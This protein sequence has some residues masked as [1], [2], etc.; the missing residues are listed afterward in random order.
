MVHVD[1]THSGLTPGQRTTW[2]ARLAAPV[3]AVLLVCVWVAG[4]GKVGKPKTKKGEVGCCNIAEMSL[5]EG[6]GTETFRW[7]GQKHHYHHPHP[8][9]QN[10][11]PV[12]ALAP[13]LAP[14]KE[15]TTTISTTTQPP[16]L[17]NPY[18]QKQCL[19]PP[20][21]TTVTLLLQG[22]GNPP[23]AGARGPV[24]SV[25]RFLPA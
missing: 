2:S 9:Y 15:L 19:R 23:G 25:S 3:R 22:A 12:P 16:P 17:T 14:S 24:D 11:P 10:S 13:L 6:V 5:S 4:M 20:T 21:C 7:P 1:P 8:Y 18:Y